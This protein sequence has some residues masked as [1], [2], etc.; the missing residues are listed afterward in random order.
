ML[1]N[2]SNLPIFFLELLT[3]IRV[4]MNFYLSIMFTNIFLRLPISIEVITIFYPIKF[5]T[6]FELPTLIWIGCRCLFGFSKIIY[7]LCLQKNFS[8]LL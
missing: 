3:L 5:L 4:I 8:F 2:L 6:S 7:L 1:T